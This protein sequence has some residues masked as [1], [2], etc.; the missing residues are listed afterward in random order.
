MRKALGK[1]LFYSFRTLFLMAGLYLGMSMPKVQ[2]AY[3]PVSHGN[4]I[5]EDQRGSTALYASD[6]LLLNEKISSIPERC[7]DPLCYAHTHNW[8][9]RGI[10]EK[11]HT[12]HCADCGDAGDLTSA[13][14]AEGWEQDTIFYEG[15]SY[16]GKRY[17][18]ACGYQ[19]RMELTHNFTFEV[20]DEENHRSSCALDGS[21]YCPGCEPFVEEHY[22]WYYE[23]SGDDLHHTKICFDCGYQT[24]EACFFEEEEDD[25]GSLAC[26]CGR[27]SAPDESEEPDEPDLPDTSDVP[28]MEDAPETIDAED[29]SDEADASDLPDMEDAPE[30][31]DV[32]S[33]PPGD[34][35]IIMFGG[36]DL[37]CP[38]E[39][40]EKE[41]GYLQ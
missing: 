13:H 38:S 28:D 22:A 35:D 11:T 31:P 18:C 5:Y 21:P 9:Y 25:E 8:E 12:R 30:T 17:T 39:D 19:W 24:E 15:K 2:A 33:A 16:P 26:I 34:E 6:I 36:A 3:T 40:A 14:K 10:N 27:I 41:G 32:E 4:L 1:Y 23:M 20:T 7:F 37:I 29:A